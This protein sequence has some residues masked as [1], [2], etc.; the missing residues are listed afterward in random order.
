[1]EDI[2]LNEINERLNY[3][4]IILSQFVSNV[5]VLKQ[6]MEHKFG[7]DI[8]NIYNKIKEENSS[9][10]RKITRPRNVEE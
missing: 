1:M 6:V 10:G 4:D 5:E 9:G 7:D 8:N 3:I 2:S